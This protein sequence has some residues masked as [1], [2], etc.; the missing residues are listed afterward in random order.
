[1]AEV[2]KVWLLVWLNWLRVTFVYQDWSRF[3]V[4]FWGGK[5]WVVWGGK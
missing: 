2:L 3:W 4:V 5:C 1:M